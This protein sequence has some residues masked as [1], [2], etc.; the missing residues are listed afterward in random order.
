MPHQRHEAG[1]PRQ[2]LDVLVRRRS[3]LAVI[4][5]G[6]ALGALCRWQVGRLLPTSSGA[7][8]WSTF[9]INVSGAFAL[10]VLMVLVTD[11]LPPSRHLRPFVGVGFLGGY[12]T[13]ST[14]ALETRGLLAGGHVGLAAAYLL[15]TLVAGLLATWLAI[16]VARAG[17]ASAR[18]RARRR[19]EEAG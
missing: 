18:A 19:A 3:V 7:F 15:G 11:L 4:S 10:G 8:P 16:V 6:G 14:Y 2:A 1:L 13:F 17:V 9:W 5:A 12:T